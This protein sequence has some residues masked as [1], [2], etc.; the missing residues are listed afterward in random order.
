MQNYSLTIA[1]II[2]T[3]ALPILVQVGLQLGLS[4]NCSNEIGLKIAPIIAMLPGA[5]IAWIGRVK[6][7]GIKISGFKK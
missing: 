4:D 5:I 1:G 2:A 3:V 6:T 7:G